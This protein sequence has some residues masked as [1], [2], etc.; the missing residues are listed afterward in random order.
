MKGMIFLAAA[1]LS[2]VFGS[3]MLSCQ[4]ALAPP[5]RGRCHNRFCGFFYVSELFIKN[6]ASIC[7]LCDLGRHRDGFD[8]CDRV[9]Y[10]SGAI[11]SQNSYW[12]CIDHLRRL[13]AQFKAC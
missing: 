12:A 11:Q 2:E 5:A 1:I 4:K 13:F 8:S 7:G 9:F 10:I 3:T 6:T